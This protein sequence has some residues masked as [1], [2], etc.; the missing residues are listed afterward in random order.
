MTERNFDLLEHSGRVA[1]MWTRGVKLEDEAIAQ[2]KNVLELPFIHKHVAVMPDAHWGIGA[3]IGSVIPTKGAIIPS[4]VGVDIGCGMRA[5]PTSLEAGQ[6][7]DLRAIRSAIENA[8]PHGRT[9]NGGVG[10]KGAWAKV[11]TYIQGIWR[12]E[13]EAEF[14]YIC[15][16]HQQLAQSNNVNHLGTLGT[17]NHFIEI[18]IDLED[19]VWFVLHSGSRGVGAKIGNYFIR[20]AKLIAKQW[21]IELPDAH[22]AYFPEGTSYFTDYVAALKW[23]QRYA[24]LN[25]TIMMDRV[26]NAIKKLLPR[27]DVLDGV[28]DCH[29]NFADQEKHYGKH[30]WVIRKGAIRAREDDWG[31]IPGSMGAKSFIVKG[32]GNRESFMSC[33]HGAGRAMSRKAAKAAFTLKDHRAATEGIECRKDSDVLDETPGAYKD[34]EAV[35][36]AQADLV[37]IKHTLRQVVCVKG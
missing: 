16:G 29:H 14:E 18:C 4:A 37:E 22:L 26:L 24:K 3:T 19:K 8:V 12:K 33:S 35:M 15:S 13:L 5:I 25:R 17:G 11:P 31:I 27:F 7:K 20:M 21:F 23:A 36:S 32:K 2:I 6:L 1:K 28:V 30:I 9:H 10:D 34:I